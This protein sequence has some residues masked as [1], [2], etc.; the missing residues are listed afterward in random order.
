MKV[1]F[2]I[3]FILLRFSYS[4]ENNF[5]IV[6]SE[7]MSPSINAGDFIWTGPSIDYSVGDIVFFKYPLNE[8]MTYLKRIV[9]IGMGQFIEGRDWK[10]Y[11]NGEVF[12]ENT[13][14][15]FDPKNILSEKLQ[16][17]EVKLLKTKTGNI[18]HYIL[19]DFNIDTNKSFKQMI[20]P[21]GKYFLVGDNRDY[22]VDSRVWGAADKEHILTKVKYVF[23]QNRTNDEL[24]NTCMVNNDSEACYFLSISFMRKI[25]IEMAQKYANKSCS[26]GNNNGCIASAAALKASGKTWEA[27]NVLNIV[28]AKNN[29]YACRAAQ[30]IG[31]NLEVD[32]WPEE[33]FDDLV[34]KE[35]GELDQ[36]FEDATALEKT[37]ES[38]SQEELIE[39]GKQKESSQVS[40]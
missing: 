16:K 19:H 17:A 32:K 36:M 13:V 29:V 1:I 11:V 26:L 6:P 34:D 24:I 21:S 27:I 38:T 3:F 35:L 28:C 40:E 31:S 15:D 23:Y 37:P 5:K 2:I 9:A 10:L 30:K 33:A 8:Q 14:N 39:Q 4:E 20:L 22:S 25:N 12:E 7:G 18:E